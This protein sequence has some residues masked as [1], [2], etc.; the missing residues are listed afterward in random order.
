MPGRDVPGEIPVLQVG[1]VA[2]ST[3]RQEFIAHVVQSACVSR[4][5]LPSFFGLEVFPVLGDQKVS[6][7]PLG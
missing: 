5:L 3:L 1:L 2:V 4:R 7:N 6:F